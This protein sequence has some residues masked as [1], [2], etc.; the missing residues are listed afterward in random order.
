[1]SAGIGGHTVGRRIDATGGRTVKSVKKKQKKHGKSRLFTRIISQKRKK[2][3][4]C[5]GILEVC[6]DILEVC[7]RKHT[8][9]GAIPA[10][11]RNIGEKV[12]GKYHI[13]V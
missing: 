2:S 10:D 8:E 5:P 1:M 9:L 7:L 11:I 3:N 12:P 4:R 13:A 6:R